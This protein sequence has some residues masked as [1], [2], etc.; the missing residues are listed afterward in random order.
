[1]SSRKARKKRRAKRDSKP[2]WRADD[3]YSKELGI[4]PIFVFGCSVLEYLHWEGFCLPG[5]I[6]FASNKPTQRTIRHELIHWQQYKELCF[7]PFM[8]V[9]LLFEMYAIVVNRSFAKWDENPFEM[10]CYMNERKRT[11]LQK[12]KFC[13]WI[14]YINARH[15]THDDGD[16]DDDTDDD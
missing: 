2:K 6:L 15:E 12:R 5:V 14:D 1:M 11:Y 16:D 8:I 7:V 10:E 3:L 13:A 4:F 9:Y